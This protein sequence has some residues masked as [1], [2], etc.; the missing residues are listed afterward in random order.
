M[1]SSRDFWT[2]LIIL[3]CAG[4]LVLAFDLFI[5]YNVEEKTVTP[6]EELVGAMYDFATPA[7][8]VAKQQRVQELLVPEEWERL[9]LDNSLRVVNTYF[10]FKY[11]ASEAVPVWEHNQCI[12]YRLV[13]EHI[14]EWRR[15]LLLYNVNEE[16]QLYDVKEYEL[17]SMKGSVSVDEFK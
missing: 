5:W 7:E 4:S 16:G 6:G 3:L 2:K 13:N 1:T 17:V 15:Y 12:C 9:R 14:G 10:K 8:L 11:S